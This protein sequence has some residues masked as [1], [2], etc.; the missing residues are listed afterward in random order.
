MMNS[1]LTIVHNKEFSESGIR[2]KEVKQE[3]QG[4]LSGNKEKQEVCYEYHEE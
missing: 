3:E 1:T 4:L 2:A